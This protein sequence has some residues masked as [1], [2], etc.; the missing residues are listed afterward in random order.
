MESSPL[1]NVQIDE[2]QFADKQ[3]CL[4]RDPAQSVS[5]A[6]IMRHSEVTRIEQRVESVPDVKTQQRYSRHTHSAV[7]VEVRVDE[8]LGTIHVSRVVSAIAGG[9]ILNPKTAANQIA[10]SVVWGHRHG[11]ARGQHHRSPIWPHRQSQFR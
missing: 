2:V 9:R 1:A 4:K 7:F 5:M 3:L 8:D 6:E 11:I 10:G